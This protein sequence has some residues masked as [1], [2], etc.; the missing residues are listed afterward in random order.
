VIMRKLCEEFSLN[1]II[2]FFFYFVKKNVLKK[3]KKSY[4]NKKQI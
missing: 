2:Y 1:Q 3:L 4:A